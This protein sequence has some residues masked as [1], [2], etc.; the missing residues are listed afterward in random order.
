MKIL[1]KLK[2]EKGSIT[3]TV[4]AA[5]LFIISA[6]LIAYFSLSNQ[7]NDQ[8]KKT[9]QV[10]DS[11]KVT[12]TDLVQKYKDVQDNFNEVTTMSIAE[13]KSLGNTMLA[14]GTNTVVNDE[15]GN[16]FVV[17][18]GFKVTEDANNV[19]EGVVIQDKDGNEFVWIPV[20]E[21][22]Y[23]DNGQKKIKTINL[24]RYLF[25]EDGE[26]YSSKADGSARIPQNRK[27]EYTED[28]IQ[29]QYG[30][31]IAKNISEFISGTKSN[32]GFYIG[33][34]EARIE[35]YSGNVSTSNTNN[36]KSWTGYNGGKLVEKPEAH[37]FNYITQ[38]KA[39]ELSIAMYPENQNFQ[40]DLCNSYAWD[41]AVFFLQNFDN[42]ANAVKS[43]TNFNLNYSRQGSLSTEVIRNNGTSMT[44]IAES[45]IDRICNIYDMA[46]NAYEWST[47]TCNDS[48]GFCVQRGAI[49]NKGYTSWV[50]TSSST[51]TAD[52]YNSFRP[53]LYIK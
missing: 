43:N 6:I 34:Y 22:R 37:V 21:I 19:T 38:N 48:A 45:E 23:E 9:R 44:G 8:S 39:S 50:S 18:A 3:M 31:A 10:A 51:T 5:M 16:N 13:V 32:M 12:N 53:I 28:E 30:N 42:R 46:A 15:L 29:S 47:E 35:G 11:Y 40:S 27:I 1:R 49:Y 36:E 26:I 14:K 25:N 33:R 2:E 20:G 7:S 17:P 52:F 24:G 41:T 4:V